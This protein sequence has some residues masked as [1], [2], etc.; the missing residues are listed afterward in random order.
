MIPLTVP[1]LHSYI[2]VVKV[3]SDTKM[4][5]QQAWNDMVKENPKFSEKNLSLRHIFHHKFPMD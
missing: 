5:T 3:P 2:V 4:S 1:R